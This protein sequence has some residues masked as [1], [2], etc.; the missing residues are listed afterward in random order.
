MGEAWLRY[1]AEAVRGEAHTGA[2]ARRA[3]MSST[4]KLWKREEQQGNRKTRRAAS[5]LV[6]TG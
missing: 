4:V 3:A 6:A 1:E 5:E 2:V